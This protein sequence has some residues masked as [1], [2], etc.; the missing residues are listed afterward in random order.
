M[1][2]DARRFAIRYAAFSFSVSV[3]PQPIA[4]G[5]N[6]RDVVDWLKMRTASA[7]H[8]QRF[9]LYPPSNTPAGIFFTL[10]RR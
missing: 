6:I 10:C 7:I 1:A 5:M 3:F 2:I 4:Q 8:G 9:G